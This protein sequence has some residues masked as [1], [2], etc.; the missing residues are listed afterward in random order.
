MTWSLLLQKP[1]TIYRGWW[2]VLTGLLAVIVST[3]ST[4]YVFS[5]LVSAMEAD[6]RWSRTVLFGARSISGVVSGPTSALLGPLVDVHGTRLAMTVS[7][8]MGGVCLVLLGAI[9]EPWQYYLLMGVGLA[10]ARP[11]LLGLGPRTAVAN[12]FIRHRPAAY[13]LLS[14]GT[15]LSGVFLVP[16]LAWVATNSSWRLA[17]ILLGLLEACIIAPLCWAVVRRRP[18]DLG[19]LPDGDR[20]PATA[21]NPSKGQPP[22]PDVGSPWTVREVFRTKTFWLLVVGFMLTGFPGSSIFLHLVAYLEGKGFSALAASSALSLYAIAALFGRPFWGFLL[23]RYGMYSTLVGF[24]LA[25]GM[26]ILLL[27][28]SL[29]P[30]ANVVT[31]MLVGLVI[32]GSGQLQA[33]IWPDY[34]GRGIVGS[35]TGYTTFIMTPASAGGPVIAAFMFDLTNSYQAIFLI[36]GLLCF[37]AGISFLLARYPTKGLEEGS[38]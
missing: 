34:Y 1:K 13:S 23:A 36:F 18:E 24:A 27:V 28:W 4:S 11:L 14:S 2:I 6:L 15:P 33:Q 22:T 30:L 17:W 8:V 16:P 35:L 3:S 19:L 7:A 38:I 37:I 32:G 12:W 9:Q 29:G 31:T 21:P 20:S 26:A 5:I 10:A 25:Y